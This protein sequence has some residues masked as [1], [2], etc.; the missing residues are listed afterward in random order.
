[1]RLIR[2][3]IVLVVLSVALGVVTKMA[4]RPACALGDARTM[5]SRADDDVVAL[6]DAP[7][8]GRPT[9]VEANALGAAAR[10]YG[11]EH[12]DVFADMFLAQGRLWVGFTTDARRHLAAIRARVDH[13]EGLGAFIADF[14][15][16]DLRALQ[17]RITHDLPTLDHEGIHVTIVA[18]DVVHNRVEVGVAGVGTDAPTVLARRYG[19]A[20]LLI[21]EGFEVHTVPSDVRTAPS[22]GSAFPTTIPDASRPKC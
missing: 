4:Q 9:P 5:T 10:A 20:M 16:R 17:D 12:P 7:P 13:P 18:I 21:R 15:E 1:M 6:K 22:S 3:M 14:P 2:A 8:L 19:P 11:A